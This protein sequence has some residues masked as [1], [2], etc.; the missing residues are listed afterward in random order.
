[1]TNYFIHL[2]NYLMVKTCFLS[3]EVWRGDGF[4]PSHLHQK[5]VGSGGICSY[6]RLGGLGS[7][8]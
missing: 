4:K 5:L 8:T 6:L 1:M 7:L 2:N 3:M